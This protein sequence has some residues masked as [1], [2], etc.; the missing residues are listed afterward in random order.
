MAAKLALAL[1]LSACA[2]VPVPNWVLAGASADLDFANG[3]YFTPTDGT[4]AGNLA[5]SRAGAGLAQKADGTWQS[6]AA[7]V[8]RITD[9]GL[10][11]EEARTNSVRNNSNA[12]ASAPA[13]PPTN[14]SIVNA[15][16]LAT[17]LAFGT[18]NGLPYVDLAVSGTTST[19]NVEL[20]WE[21]STAVAAVNGQA[22]A[23]SAFLSLK[24][25]DFTNL[26][27][28]TLGL[29][30]RRSDGVSLTVLRSGDLKASI[31]A[32][33][34]RFTNLQTTNDATVAFV[35]PR[36]NFSF[37][38]GVTVNFT[39]RLAGAQLELGGFITSPILT[40]LA[41]VTRPADIVTLAGAAQ[42]AGLAA[43]AVR[44]ESN[45]V[46]G[47]TSNNRLFEYGVTG[48]LM[49]FTSSVNLFIQAIAAGAGANIAIGGG[50]TTAGL[51]KAVGSFDASGFSVRANG[52]APSSNAAAFGAASAP[53]YVANNSAGVRALNGYLRRCTFGPTKGQFDGLTS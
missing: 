48:S 5:C 45:L 37:S 21:A 18:E 12:G 36:I 11:V 15:G 53:I 44:F 32:T 6:F 29:T 24:A 27:Q 10:L 20:R 17:S 13:T 40:T 49:A 50:G 35:Q 52:S 14:W 38:S 7:N 30:Q 8:P 16:T 9:Q 28:V 3:R 4:L 19:S 1:N 26:S 41:A 51:V 42:A 23:Q 46:A 33:S 47:M 22:W 34:A 2:P 25:G 31:N 39:V 43:K